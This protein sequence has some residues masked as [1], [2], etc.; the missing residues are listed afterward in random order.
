[1]KATLQ[2]AAGW[3]ISFLAM[4]P[5][6]AQ[7]AFT[8]QGQLKD[9]GV[10]ASGS[11]DLVFRLFGVA[12]G[13][14]PVGS[15]VTVNDWPVTNGLFAVSLDFGA[16]H[17]NGSARWLQVEVRLGNSNG[18]YSV[19]FPRQPL[20]ATPYALHSLGDSWSSEGSHIHNNNS[21]NIGIGTHAP[22]Q[23]LHIAK[24]VP[25]L[26]L[27]DSD[28]TTNQ[29]GYVGFNDQDGLQ[30]GW[31][32]FGSAGNAHLSL[33]NQR[34][35]G[36]TILGSAGISRLVLNAAG[37]VGIGTTAPADRLH[38]VGSVFAEGS[39]RSI[40][41]SS[42]SEVFLGWG[43]DSVGGD[44]ARIRIGGDGV[45]AYN[46]LEIQAVANRS[47][48]RITNAGDVGIGTSNPANRLSVVGS[49]NIS[50]RLGV[51]LSNPQVP[52]HV[53]GGSD[54]SLSGGGYIVTGGVDQLNI[55]ID[56][57][58]IMARNNGEVSTLHL[59]ANGGNVA[60]GG[61]IEMGH[62]IVVTGGASATC[63]AET[64]VIG[65]G[66]RIV[67]DAEVRGSYPSG[68]RWNCEVGD[69]SGFITLTSYAICARMQ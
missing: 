6:H 64:S 11:Y 4:V 30:R 42:D 49:A 7:T 27:Q 36:S 28:S 62:Q 69:Q 26:I 58:E 9:A 2:V 25:V 47:L 54:S 16:G 45:G 32:G 40:S 20:T 23:P 39:L 65:G 61:S 52:V 15:P 63:P 44:M 66:C 35:G 29:V 12:S 38:V 13:G 43:S 10:P 17:F 51:G 37:D 18:S 46:G 50:A 41:S 19:L 57:N 48:L 56:N 5:V 55:S 59:N 60:V 21:G 14:S 33:M 53:G 24:D 34:A 8:Y 3:G 1:M 68:N 67:G 31:M 22:V